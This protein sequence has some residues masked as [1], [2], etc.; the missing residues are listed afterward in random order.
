LKRPSRSF[1]RND[2]A[3]STADVF[4]NGFE[5]VFGGR[6]LVLPETT[7]QTPGL[8]FPKTGPWSFGGR[9]AKT[10]LVVPEVVLRNALRRGAVVVSE[11]DPPSFLGSLGALLESAGSRRL[12]RVCLSTVISIAPKYNSPLKTAGV[13]EP[14]H[15]SIDVTVMSSVS[16]PTC[17]A[18]NKL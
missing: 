5:V 10:G 16:V 17:V 11:N 1:C 18:R 12:P 2:P 3:K 9:L 14:E 7:S 13:F 6:F 8:P 4:K 15:I